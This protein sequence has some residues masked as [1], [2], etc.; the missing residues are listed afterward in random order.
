MAYQ[1]PSDAEIISEFDA[2]DVKVDNDENLMLA[3]REYY[4]KYRLDPGDLSCV[5]MAHSLRNRNCK[6]SIV[7]VKDIE[8]ECSRLSSQKKTEEEM[9]A[10]SEVHTPDPETT[11]AT[12][13]LMLK[14]TSDENVE[15]K[16]KLQSSLEEA[17]KNLPRRITKPLDHFTRREPGQSNFSRLDS[18]SVVCSFGKTENV[19]WSGKKGERKSIV[20]IYG[21]DDSNPMIKLTYMRE[22]M[23]TI[24]EFFNK[25]IDDMAAEMR[26]HGVVEEFADVTEPCHDHTNTIIGKVY[27]FGHG[28]L[29]PQAVHFE[30]S[31]S[32]CNGQNV[33]LDLQLLSQYA[34]F[35]GQIA[36]FRGYNDVGD[37]FKCTE[38][39]HGI[40]A[41]FSP[42][43]VARQGSLQLVIAAGPFATAD[44]NFDS[45]RDFM[46]YVKESEPDVCILLG[47]FLNTKP[48]IT[49]D[50]IEEFSFNT[51]FTDCIKVIDNVMKSLK[52]QVVIVSSQREPGHH[53]IYPT[54]PYTIMKGLLR[55]YKLSIHSQIHNN[56]IFVPDPCL[57]DIDGVIIGV[58]T[59]D[60]IFQLAREEMAFG[61]NVDRIIRLISHLI[62][63]RSFY[64]LYPAPLKL[65]MAWSKLM[66]TEMKCTPHVLILPSELAHYIK[67]VQGCCC[68]NPKF[69]GKG[70]GTFARME[71]LLKNQDG[72]VS[73]IPDISCEIIKIVEPA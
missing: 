11:I 68:I 6:L 32:I 71:I 19:Q 67:D 10:K 48:P 36:A 66:A 2:F 5:W 22:N 12:Y 24:T 1:C 62:N 52:T 57:L 30:S 29:N 42:K 15:Q 43:Q 65:N 16:R 50:G 8:R 63:Q 13:K 47:P 72:P 31:L 61:Y 64:P 33:R 51:I 55:R 17:I 7:N 27:C 28:K 4:I 49:P 44:N 53:N 46:K 73:L 56:I 23:Q 69:K 9:M 38:H 25:T 41:E 40:M 14:Y 26:S 54:P 20:S 34:V 45:F 3:L 39:I 37:V 59:N 18:A 70:A 21:H 58:T 60:T 35:P